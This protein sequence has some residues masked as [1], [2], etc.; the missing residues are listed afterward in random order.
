M[1]VRVIPE[2]AEGGYPE[3]IVLSRGWIPCSRAY[4][5]APE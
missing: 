1:M 3:S 2:A 4:A 5:R